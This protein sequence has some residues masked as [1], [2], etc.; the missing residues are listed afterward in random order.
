[1]RFVSLLAVGLC[2]T[3]VTSF[4]P[5]QASPAVLPAAS[6]K[7]SSSLVFRP[8]STT[9]PR[10]FFS[11]RADLGFLFFR[12]HLAVGYGLPFEN[13]VGAELVPIISSGQVGGYF[14]LRYRNPWLKLRSGGLLSQSFFFSDL[15]PQASY[16]GRDLMTLD[17]PQQ[18][19]T[20]SD[21]EMTLSL[22]TPI[23]KIRSETQAIFLFAKQRRTP[24]Y[25]AT[26]GAIIGA[27]FAL[28]QQVRMLYSFE[29]VTGLSV[30]P[31]F[32]VVISP[33]RDAR[34]IIRGGA[35]A[36][37][38]LYDDLELRTNLMPNLSAPDRLGRQTNH[39]L[40]VSARF[41][42]ASGQP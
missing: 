13:W 10:L 15:S 25:V 20:A 26:L 30:G 14:G 41:R 33:Y 32:E 38:W 2:L 31:A 40:Q 36:R 12:P 5:A 18:F 42:W 6:T 19:Y 39:W 7:A 34:P 4:A 17:G 24:V 28:R 22:S 1:M 29:R 11:A 21:S 35:V 16:D 27:P 9:R 8:W 23:G 3:L 37:F